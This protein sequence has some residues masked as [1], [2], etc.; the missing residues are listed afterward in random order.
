MGGLPTGEYDEERFGKKLDDKDAEIL[1]LNLRISDLEHKL[2][3]RLRDLRRIRKFDPTH[4]N[5]V[6]RDHVN[7]PDIC[8]PREPPH[9]YDIG[10][11]SVKLYDDEGCEAHSGEVFL[12][13]LDASAAVEQWRLDTGGSGVVLR[14]IYNSARTGRAC[15]ASCNTRGEV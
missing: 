1:M 12:G 10:R 5:R 7:E 13:L 11:Y 6:L 4:Y 3:D 14:C 8:G 9:I 15:L 2:T